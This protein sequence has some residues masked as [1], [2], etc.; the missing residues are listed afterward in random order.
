MPEKVLAA[1]PEGP[2]AGLDP[3]GFVGQI[4]DDR[5][6]IKDG[7]WTEGTGLKGFVGYGYCY[8]GDATQA[9]ITFKLPVKISSKYEILLAYQPHENRGD[10]VPVTVTIGEHSTDHVINMRK[11]PPVDDGF[12]SLGAIA[13]QKDDVVEVR[14]TTE[15]A[16]GNVHADAVWLKPIIE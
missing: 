13:V 9:A 16:G 2:P 7:N 5:D 1:R 6:A 14:L 10:K 3:A 8:A 11:K 4:A 15:Q 12:I